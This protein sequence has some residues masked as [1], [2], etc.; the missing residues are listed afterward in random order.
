MKRWLWLLLPFWLLA[1]ERA[2]PYLSA[3]GG[4]ADYQDDGRLSAVESKDVARVHFN[5]GAFINE[6]LS[7]ELA[8]GHFND[9][10]GK[11]QSGR[12]VRE[13]FN[14]FSAN[15]LAHYPVMEDQIDLFGK[16]GAGQIFW[17]ETGPQTRSSSS[18]ALVYGIGIGVRPLPWL[19]LNLG[20]DLNTFRMDTNTTQYDMSLG[21]AYL[22]LQVQ[23]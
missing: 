20:Y 3:G 6:N 9:F 22:E 10:S 19:T 15:V 12:S 4:L 11:D 18:A 17:T 14:I 5:A 16:F 13:S 21:T 23:F 8:F 7:V 1:G 2:G